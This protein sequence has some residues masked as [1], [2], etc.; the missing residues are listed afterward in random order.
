MAVHNEIP[1][2]SGLGSSGAAIVG[3][4]K[5]AGL[6]SGAEL[7]NQTIQ[8]YATE[9]EG[10][11][12]NVGATLHGGFV[13]SCVAADGNVAS[14]K[15]DWPAK[16][17][18][19]VVSPHSQLPT[20]VARAALPRTLSRSDAVFNLQRSSLF[21][22]AVAT[23]RH[24]LFAEAMKDRLHQPRRES[25]VPG[26]SEALAMPATKGLLGIALSGAGPSIIALVTDNEES[27]AK[28]MAE[29]FS[30]HKIRS[31]TR[32]LEVDNQGLLSDML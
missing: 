19:V 26:L 18:T 6:L 15:F 11:P 17:R 21:T 16:I 29:C 10:H 1:L 12:D 4:I 27:I 14:V 31:T 9:F 24:D 32:I 22:A 2:A 20:H 7:T 28:N 30:R 5:L 23:K 13:T 3:G 25:L 8:N